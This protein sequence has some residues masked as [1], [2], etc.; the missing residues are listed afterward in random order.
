MVQCNKC[1]QNKSRS[2][3]YTDSRNRS[4]IETQC[5]ACRC[6]RQRQRLST[7]EGLA[8]H[9]KCSRDG[10]QRLKDAAYEAYGGYR[11]VCCGE[12]EPNFLSLD[13]IHNDGAIHR[14]EVS[15]SNFYRWLRDR[16]YPPI[17]QILCM[18][19]NVGRHRNGGICPHRV[20]VYHG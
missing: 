20:E 19:C 1:L 9:R 18:N 13:H 8:K 5:K 17:L 11:C 2:D 16:D 14:K 6:A 4:G 15:G 3:F 7:A 10:I 12:T